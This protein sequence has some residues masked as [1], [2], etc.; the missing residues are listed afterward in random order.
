[1]N[2][3]VTAIIYSTVL[4]KTMIQQFS[5]VLYPEASIDLT[6]RKRIMRL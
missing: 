4:G 2:L 3:H 6:P 5:D 1:M